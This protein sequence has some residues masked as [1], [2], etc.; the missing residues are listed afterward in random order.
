MEDFEHI[1]E[2]SVLISRALSG[3][4][5][6]ADFEELRDDIDALYETVLPIRS[7]ANADYIPQLS[8]KFVDPELFGISI[9]TID[10]QRSVN[11]FV[12]VDA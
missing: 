12:R 2:H 1:R 8:E 10:G 6:V 7:G 5:V 4:L 3:Q 11:A 9:C